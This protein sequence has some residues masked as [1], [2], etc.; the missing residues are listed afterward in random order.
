M[1]TNKVSSILQAQ[2]NFQA[3]Y[4]DGNN[5][6]ANLTFAPHNSNENLYISE[7]TVNIKISMNDKVSQCYRKEWIICL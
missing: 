3:Q 2:F 6:L 4:I 5:F 1:T 7:Y